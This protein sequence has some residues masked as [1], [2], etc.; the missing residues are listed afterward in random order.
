MDQNPDEERKACPNCGHSSRATA[1]ICSHCGYVFFAVRENGMVRKRCAHCGHLNRMGAKVCTN[2]GSAF[3]GIAMISRGQAQKW[4][5]QCGAPRRPTA[6]VCSQCGYHFKSTPIE[7]PLVHPNP[8]AVPIA[9]A[10]PVPPSHPIRHAR[11]P[12]IAGEPAPFL[13]DDE[14]NRLRDV[15]NQNVDVFVRL[16]SA[17]R[18]DKS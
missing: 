11:T 12:D 9:P 5:P 17:L 18:S 14:L 1:K 15:G 8:K 4:C 7:P 6:K 13:S 16:F 2:C 10:Q 3:S